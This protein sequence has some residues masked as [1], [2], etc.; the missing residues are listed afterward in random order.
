MNSQRANEANWI[1]WQCLKYFS[2]AESHLCSKCYSSAL[3]FC[4][5]HKIED[6]RLWICRKNNDISTNKYH[7]WES[8]LTLNSHLIEK[9]TINWMK[10]WCTWSEN[11]DDYWKHESLKTLTRRDLT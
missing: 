5:S 1:H 6:E 11:A 8:T 10:L 4:K 2:E 7:T 9:V 3:Q